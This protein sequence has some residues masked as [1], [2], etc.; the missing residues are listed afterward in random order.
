MY[1]GKC[2]GIQIA[3]RE[4]ERERQRRRESEKRRM[5]VGSKPAVVACPIH[6]VSGIVALDNVKG[7]FLFRNLGKT[8]LQ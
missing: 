5:G 3:L 4:S 2:Q 1:M 6:S 7:T 8:Y